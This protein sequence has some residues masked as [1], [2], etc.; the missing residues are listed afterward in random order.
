MILN[1]KPLKRRCEV[2]LSNKHQPTIDKLWNIIYK[3][4]E[5]IDVAQKKSGLIDRT[6]ATKMA[7]YMKLMRSEKEGAEEMS[8]EEYERLLA[9]ELAQQKLKAEKK[10]EK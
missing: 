8:D 4:I 3:D 6:N 9:E 2:Q 1:S 5:N 10:S 7:E